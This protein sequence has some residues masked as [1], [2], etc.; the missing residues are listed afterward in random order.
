MVILGNVNVGA[1]AP[2]SLE[3]LAADTLNVADADAY[4]GHVRVVEVPG[5][6]GSSWVVQI[7]GTNRERI[8]LT[9]AASER[10]GIKLT[11]VRELAANAAGAL[12]ATPFAYG[13][14][15]MAQARERL[16]KTIPAADRERGFVHEEVVCGRDYQQILRRVAAEKM[17]LIIM[18]VHSGRPFNDMFFGST[19][20]HV[21]RG[22]DC[23]VLIVRP[24]AVL[25]S[26]SGGAGV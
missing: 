8:L 3:S 18:G 2:T 4:P 20:H 7:S 23:P 22:A 12:G 6:H 26:R 21:V 15:L 16:H 5:L 19:T 11:P 9:E 10:L 25:S 24:S 17:D 13:P 14:V 1:E